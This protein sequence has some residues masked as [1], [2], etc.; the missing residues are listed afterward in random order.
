[1]GSAMG[2][3]FLF[4][5]SAGFCLLVALAI[6]KWILKADISYESFVKNKMALAVLIPVCLIFSYLT[7]ARN[8][9][10]KDNSTMFMADL[11]KS[12]NNARLNYYV[13]NELVE[14]VL[15]TVQDSTQ[16]KEILAE[17]VARLNKAI[18]ISKPAQIY[19]DAHTELGTAYLNM[20]RYDSAERHF[21]IAIAQNDYQSIASNNLGT[22]YLRTDRIPEA[23]V[24]Y[25]E[26]IRIKADFVQAYANLGSCYA[27]IKQFDSAILYLNQCLAINPTYAEA[28]MQLGLAYYFSNKFNEAEPYFKKALELNPTDLNAANNLGACYLN[29]GKYPQAVEIFKQLVAANPGY[30]NGYSN[31]GH[32][33]YEMKQY[34][35]AIEVINKSLQLDPNNVKDIP[36]IAL[37]YKALG[38]MAEAKQ[39]EAIAQKYYSNFKL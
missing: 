10:W 37:S 16:R 22:V 31:L 24:H 8:A 13:G 23:I 3:R 29:A 15:P 7:F 26:A 4:F 32:C 20:M 38:K 25:K 9:E 5:A 33:Y 18:E 21:K 17:S 12:P 6:E 34:E 30:V 39:Y 14:N 28:Y 11:E 36:Y 2:E 35:A 1:M 27:R 19:T